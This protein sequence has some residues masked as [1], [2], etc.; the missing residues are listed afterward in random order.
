MVPEK[1]PGINRP[2]YSFVNPNT[3]LFLTG[4]PL[5]GKSTIA[6]LVASSIEGCTVQSM[7]IIRLLVQQMELQRPEVERN[8]FVRYGACDSF[9]F[10]GDGSYTPRSLII[11]FN[12]YAQAVGSLLDRIVP[13]LEAQGAQKVLFEGVQITPQIAAPFLTDG[14]KLIIVTS[15][16]TKLRSN[17]DKRYGQDAELVKRYSV[18]RLLLLQEEIVRQ[19]Q[20]LPPDKRFFIHDTGDYLDSAERIIRLLIAAGIIA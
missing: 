17:R 3:S 9:L 18:D 14:N 10:V 2:E 8:P 11:G 7:D 13:K 16:A 12:S 4:T 5:S 15:E 20:E 6:P 1:S 19:G